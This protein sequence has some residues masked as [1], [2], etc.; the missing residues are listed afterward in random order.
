M[1]S[2]EFSKIKGR[3]DQVKCQ[4]PGHVKLSR[5]LPGLILVSRRDLSRRRNNC[6]GDSG[7]YIIQRIAATEMT[8]IQRPFEDQDYSPRKR[9]KTSEL[10]LTSTQRSTVDSLIH[11]IKKKG[12]YDALRKLVWAQYIE[13]VRN[14]FLRPSMCERPMIV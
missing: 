1:E 5:Q 14:V 10:P 2:K 11:T 6:A 4:A 13:S 12:E 9:F 8:S 7:T 3:R